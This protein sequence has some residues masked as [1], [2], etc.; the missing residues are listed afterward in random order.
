M[1][2]TKI[3][4]IA[5]RFYAAKSPDRLEELTKL[6]SEHPVDKPWEIRHDLLQNHRITRDKVED[7]LIGTRE[8]FH[9]H[10]IELDPTHLFDN[11]FN[12]KCGLR[13]F[14]Q[15]RIEYP[16]KDLKVGYIVT[17]LDE[18]NAVRSKVRKCG[19][20]GHQSEASSQTGEASDWCPK[21]HLDISFDHL[22]LTY[23]R[24]LHQPQLATQEQVE[25]RWQEVW[26]LHLSNPTSPIYREKI[27]KRIKDIS[28]TKEAFIKKCND[29]M[30]IL[31]VLIKLGV[32][33]HLIE[34][35]IYYDHKQAV[36]FGWRNSLS[37]SEKELL[38]SLLTDVEFKVEYK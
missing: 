12:T 10:E 4:I 2:P 17:N 23:L 15:C 24:S 6:L 37:A 34:N 1:Q 13:L 35:C 7:Q 31:N 20:C 22:H 8:G 32:P 38:Q 36:C 14:D 19:Y 5:Y 18:L 29:E 33:Y 28:E 16:N 30:D 25:A 3:L 21:P 26:P 9:F 11:Q 27:A